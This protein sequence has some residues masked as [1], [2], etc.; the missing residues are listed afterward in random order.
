MPHFTSA[1]H[2][3]TRKKPR[4]AQPVVDED[5]PEVPRGR[6]RIPPIFE[7]DE[8]DGDETL[9]PSPQS[10]EDP[11]ELDIPS[12]TEEEVLMS[13]TLKESKLWIHPPQKVLKKE[14]APLDGGFEPESPT[15]IPA[16]PLYRSLEKGKKHKN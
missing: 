14:I 16:R 4:R 13:S 9:I 1:Y 2:E 6:R 12:L 5:S 7:D 15:K 8:E 11:P 3:A 10:M